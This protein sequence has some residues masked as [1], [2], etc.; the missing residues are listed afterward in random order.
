LFSARRK[1]ARPTRRDLIITP[2]RDSSFPQVT[3]KSLKKRRVKIRARASKKISPPSSFA[4]S[5]SHIL[6]TL[7]NNAGATADRSRAET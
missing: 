7:T 2:A 6:S 1:P 3:L 5:P 4:Q